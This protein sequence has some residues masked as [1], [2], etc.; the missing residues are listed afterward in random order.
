MRDIS[1]KVNTERTATAMAVLKVSP[2]TISLIKEGRV[3]KGDPLPVAKV[4]AVQAAK[5]TSQIIPY[6]HPVP[7]DFVGVNFQVEDEQILIE[8]TVKAIYKTGVEMEALTAASVAALTIYDMTKMLDESME[9]GSVTLLRKTGGKSDFNQSVASSLSAAVI[10]LSDSVA[11]GKKE[12]ISGKLIVERL[13]HEGLLPVDYL[14]M[15]DNPELLESKI[16]YLA[17]EKKVSLIVTTGGTGLSR[18]DK[19]PEALEN[20]IEQPIPGIPEA[21]RSYGQERTPYSM[22]SRSQAGLRGGS[23]IV[24]LPGSRGGVKDSLDAIF[25]AVLHVFKMM[26]GGSHASDQKELVKP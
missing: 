5:N 9:I 2:G 16:K 23:L 17:D 3:P 26:R 10:V 20:V 25:P 18:T 13:Q 15:P 7:V 11:A 4:A 19:T 22:L 14:V 1:N 24:S 12:D 8:V 21:I 6:C